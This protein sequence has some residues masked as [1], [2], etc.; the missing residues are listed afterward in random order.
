MKISTHLKVIRL[1]SVMNM[2]LILLVKSLPLIIEYR[3]T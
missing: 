3:D 2:I 1:I